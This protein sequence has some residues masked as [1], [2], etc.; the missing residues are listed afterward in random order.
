MDEPT[1]ALDVSVQAQILNLLKELQEKFDFSYLFIT[2]DLSVIQHIGDRIVVMYLGKFVETGT[3]EE[4]FF[5]PTHPYTKAL[6]SARPTFDPS[7]KKNRVILEGDVPSPI[8][9]P[10]GCA[11]HPRC[12]ERDKHIGCGVDK[13][14]KI[15]LDGDHYLYCLPLKQ[16]KTFHKGELANLN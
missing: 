4:V 15:H 16:E 2:H 8:N 1:S 3:T 14:R 13:P 12:P 10:V 5:N 9:P 11:F 6:L 7:S